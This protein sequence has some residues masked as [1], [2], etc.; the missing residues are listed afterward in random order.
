MMRVSEFTRP[1]KKPSAGRD[2]QQVNKQE[3]HEHPD[4]RARRRR[5]PKPRPFNEPKPDELS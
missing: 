2:A 5:P 1:R 3:Q 4:T